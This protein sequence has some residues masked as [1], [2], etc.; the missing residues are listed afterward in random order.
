MIRLETEYG[1]GRLLQQIGSC[2]AFCI[3]GWATSS[4]VSN[5]RTGAHR[6]GCAAALPS[7][8]P[9]NELRSMEQLYVFYNHSVTG[10]IAAVFGGN[11]DPYQRAVR[12]PPVRNR[13]RQ[14]SPKPVWRVTTHSDRHGLSCHP[15]RPSPSCREWRSAEAAGLPVGLFLRLR[16]RLVRVGRPSGSGRVGPERPHARPEGRSFAR[17]RAV[18][19]VPLKP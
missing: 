8:L 14:R 19:G 5:S 18:G 12:G 3:S 11:L 17:H 6:R 15:L 2:W 4:R 16:W 7:A 13:G 9:S 1:R 10:R